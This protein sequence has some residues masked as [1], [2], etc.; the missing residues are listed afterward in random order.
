M[1]FSVHGALPVDGTVGSSLSYVVGIPRVGNQLRRPPY[2][3]LLNKVVRGLKRLL[4]QQVWFYGWLVAKLPGGKMIEFILTVY[5]YFTN[6]QKWKC[7]LLC[8]ICI[9]NIH[10]HLLYTLDS[11]FR[12]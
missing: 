5:M 6:K 10:F 2:G 7:I 12:K 9:V 11:D 8:I 3:S 1:I 4:W